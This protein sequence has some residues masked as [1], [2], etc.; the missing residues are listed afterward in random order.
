MVVER[1]YAGSGSRNLR[2]QWLFNQPPVRPTAANFLSLDP[3]ANP[4]L[5]RQ[6]A[7]FTTGSNIVANVLSSNYNAGTAKVTKRHSKGYSFT[8]TYTWSKNPDQGAE[9]FTVFANH[10]FI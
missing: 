5:R 8:S 10:A 7:N 9:I 4:Y 3:A 2:L 6:F 1:T